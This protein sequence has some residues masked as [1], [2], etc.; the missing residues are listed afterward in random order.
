MSL[1]DQQPRVVKP[2][3][4][5]VIALVQQNHSRGMAALT[6]VLDG[7]EALIQQ[8]R[9]DPESR[10]LARRLRWALRELDAIASISLPGD[11]P[12]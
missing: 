9:R 10:L 8:A 3:D 6:I 7:L 4:P 2:T 1:D 11:G 5:M 12:T